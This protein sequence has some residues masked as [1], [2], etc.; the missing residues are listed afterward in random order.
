M[1]SSGKTG[2][3]IAE[4]LFK[5]L[6]WTMERH[7]PATK[8]V[9]LKGR[10]LT[11][12]NCKSTGVP[13]YTGYELVQIHEARYP[14]FRAC[15]V[16]EAYEDSLP[17]SRLGKITETTSQNF[18]FSNRDQRVCFVCVAWMTGNVVAELFKWQPK[19]SYKKG[20]GFIK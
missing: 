12:I 20:E 14:I 8:T 17:C 15:E 3:L 6:G 11:T 10:G 1:K 7:Q 18:W 16:K 19:G 5:N 2:E 9:F 13:D 4:M